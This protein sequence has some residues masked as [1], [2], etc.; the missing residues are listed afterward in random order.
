MG[1]GLGDLPSGVD[2]AG[3]VGAAYEG[4]LAGQG[5]LGQRVERGVERTNGE[6]AVAR[7]P[8][9]RGVQQP[10]GLTAGLRLDVGGFAARALGQ[11]TGNSGT[12]AGPGLLHTG[13]V[14]GHVD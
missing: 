4:P 6:S 3:G 8:L 9:D 10:F 2:V 14:G 13:G 5:L 11:H 7:Q 12:P 1:K